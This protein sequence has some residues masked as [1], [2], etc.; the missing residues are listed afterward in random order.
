[1]IFEVSIICPAN[2][3]NLICSRQPRTPNKTYELDKTDPERLQAIIDIVHRANPN[4]F[5][6]RLGENLDDSRLKNDDCL[7]DLEIWNYMNPDQTYTV[8]DIMKMISMDNYTNSFIGTRG[9]DTGKELHV[10]EKVIVPGF[11]PSNRKSVYIKF[12]TPEPGS[13]ID[14][15]SFHRSKDD[16]SRWA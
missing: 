6:V 15:V 13:D 12:I 11:A 14:V 16:G 1:M 9:K 8:S 5:K 4:Q 2:I 10:F 3:L 7:E